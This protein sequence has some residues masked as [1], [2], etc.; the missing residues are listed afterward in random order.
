MLAAAVTYASVDNKWVAPV[1]APAPM[2]RINKTPTQTQKNLPTPSK[3]SLSLAKD[4]GSSYGL[5]VIMN[6]A[7]P[8]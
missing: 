7:S 3:I 1:Y 6:E 2:K 4:F 8:A 5:G